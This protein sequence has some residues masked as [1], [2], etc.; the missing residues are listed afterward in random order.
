[1]NHCSFL[2]LGVLSDAYCPVVGILSNMSVCMGG[3]VKKVDIVNS[4]R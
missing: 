4:K 2:F 1:M 3:K